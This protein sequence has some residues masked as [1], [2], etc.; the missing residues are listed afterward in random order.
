MF[1]RRIR[2]LVLVAATA[3]ALSACGSA[4][5]EAS[6]GAVASSQESPV[7]ATDGASQSAAPVAP[8]SMADLEGTWTV[9]AGDADDIESG[10][11]V[12][13]R[14]QEELRSIGAT[15]AVGRTPVVDG[16]L[17]ISDGIVTDVAVTA[18]LTALTSDSGN[19]DNA[20][21]RNGLE[22]DTFPEGTFVLTSPIELTDDA[23]SGTEFAT[24]ATG[25]LTLHGV[26]NEVTFTLNAALVGGTI[27]VAAQVDIVMSDYGVT[28][29][30]LG[31]V[32]SIADDGV[33]ELQLVFEQA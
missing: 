10:T 32:L 20:I 25:E 12:G 11:F 17:E 15:T 4:P 7:A 16:T 1:Q 5:E 9:R 24:E 31:P 14:V 13:Y 21:R 8:A 22:T 2:P 18:D 30:Q 27:V 26:T 19:R 33:A 28:P 3:V 29:P 23:L 6:V